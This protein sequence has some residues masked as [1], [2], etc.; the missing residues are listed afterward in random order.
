MRCRLGSGD[1]LEL[2]HMR[3]SET[4]D[5]WGKQNRPITKHLRANPPRTDPVP[6]LLNSS[7]LF[8]RYVR[9]CPHAL[10]PRKFPSHISGTFIAS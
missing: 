1:S 3:A 2:W 10:V 8:H 9:L 5:R 4:K 6:G 7:K